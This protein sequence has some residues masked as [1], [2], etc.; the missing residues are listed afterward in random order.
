MSCMRLRSAL[1][2]FFVILTGASLAN[3]RGQ[4]DEPSATAAPDLG[5][6][7]E[8]SPY[9]DGPCDAGK[10]V[11]DLSQLH[12]LDIAVAPSDWDSM[13]R[14]AV[15][16]PEYGGPNPTYYVAQLRWDGG[17]L[18]ED[19]SVRIKGHGS[20][21]ETAEEGRGAFPFK[22]DFDRQDSDFHMDGLKKLNLHPLRGDGENIVQEFLAYGAVR[23]HGMP[24]SRTSFVRVSLN[25]KDLGLYNALEQVD[26]RLI[27]CHFEAPHGQLYK[28]EEGEG[29]LGPEFVYDDFA[30]YTTIEHKWPETP[31]H[32]SFLHFMGEIQKGLPELTE[33]TDVE[34]I[35]K[36]FAVEAMVGNWDYYASTG[37]NYYLYEVTPGR[38]TMIIWDLDHALEGEEWC[39]EGSRDEEYPL[40]FFPLSDEESVERYKALALEFLDGAGSSARMLERLDE[41]ASVIE[42]D[43][44]EDLL[45]DMGDWVSER[46]SI[47]RAALDE[48]PAL[49]PGGE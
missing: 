30:R 35:L 27:Q 20:R 48:A 49:C 15:T 42:D 14:E 7:Q 47:L 44:P 34:G 8:W 16:L 24:A 28:G 29:G 5:E 39:G 32:A 38:F 3:C 1:G 17:T 31:D 46:E 26:G 11:F 43:L 6:P 12:T 45:V 23:E 10:D 40:A 33:V 13:R 37:H 19:V 25:G 4:S 18:G 9:T 36:Y 2:V 22:I 21:L 41:V